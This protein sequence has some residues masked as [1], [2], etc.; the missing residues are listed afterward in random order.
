MTLRV[1]RAGAARRPAFVVTMA[2]MMAGVLAG[3]VALPAASVQPTCGGKVATIVGTA[4]GELIV[5]TPRADVIAAGAG[6]DIVRGAGGNDRICGEGGADRLK[7]QDGHDRIFG[8]TG[9]DRLYGQTGGDRL[10]GNAGDDRLEG[11]PGDDSLDGGTESD[12]C[13]QGPGRGPRN[14]CERPAPKVRQLVIGGP[15][16]GQVAGA[17]W[18]VVGANVGPWGVSDG[19]CST[20][21]VNY[22]A[23]GTEEY[24]FALE[25]PLADLPAGATVLG[26]ELS[27][28]AESAAP[29]QNLSGYPANG[30]IS[31]ADATPVGPFITFEA[32]AP[33][34]QTVDVS[35]LLTPAMVTG[36]WV[37]LLQARGGAGGH[38]WGCRPADAQFPT[39]TIEYK[40]P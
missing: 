36:G 16:S 11:G 9:P 40:V 35:S 18:A 8:N 34:Y 7:G 19:A 23:S 12:A 17:F 25:F 37:G 24:R 4:R 28:S 10:Y 33:G 20:G 26:A 32:P 21:R 22:G 38:Q 15:G 31:P 27:V 1:I 2:A 13:Y 6:N 30:S 29:T 39:L 3:V 5:G 14:S